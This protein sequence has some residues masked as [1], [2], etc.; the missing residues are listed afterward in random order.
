[1]QLKAETK[2]TE[3]SRKQSHPGARPIPS[4]PYYAVSQIVQD[5]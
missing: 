1:M 2:S 3:S 4:N 5:E